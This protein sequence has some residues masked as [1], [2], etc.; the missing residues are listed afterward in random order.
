MGSCCISKQVLFN[1]R[2]SKGRPNTGLCDPGSLL[3]YR[4]QTAKPAEPRNQLGGQ[5]TAA[6]AS[7]TSRGIERPTADAKLVTSVVA[8]A[9]P[10]A[11]LARTEVAAGRPPQL[12]FVPQS[13]TTPAAA[14]QQPE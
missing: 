5:H 10:A 13:L 9:A 4:E 3:A 1:K 7:G 12:S 2:Y 8:P 11:A 6:A 14:V